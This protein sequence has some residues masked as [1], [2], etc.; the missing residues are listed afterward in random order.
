MYV[1][2]NKFRVIEW[3]LDL[4][5]RQT[6]EETHCYRRTDTDSPTGRQLWAKQFASPKDGVT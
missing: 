6:N 2:L 3:T 4:T 1:E 5:D